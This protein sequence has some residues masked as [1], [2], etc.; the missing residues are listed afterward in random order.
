[1]NRD[2]DVNFYVVLGDN[3]IAKAL[4][5]EA[6][7][8]S[9][10]INYML[11]FIPRMYMVRFHHFKYYRLNKTEYDDILKKEIYSI[12]SKIDEDKHIVLVPC[13]RFFYDFILRNKQFF[14]CLCVLDTDYFLERG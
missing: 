4:I 5:S 11:D 12:L 10:Q 1:M 13:D 2:S 3:H 8:K 14:E 6:Y 9:R 7:K